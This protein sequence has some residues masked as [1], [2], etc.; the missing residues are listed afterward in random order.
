MCIVH[1][2]N[3]RVIT[4]VSFTSERCVQ[5]AHGVEHARRAHDR[6]HFGS[7]TGCLR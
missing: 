1:E 2:T 3:K 5:H 4:A 6:V 7:I